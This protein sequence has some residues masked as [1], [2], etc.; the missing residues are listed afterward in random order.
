[1]QSIIRLG[2]CALMFSAVGS[3]N[4][5]LFIWNASQSI[6]NGQNPS[7]GQ[8]TGITST[9]DNVS[10]V[11]TWEV[12]FAPGLLSEGFTL[13]V[14]NGP[15]PKGHDG[16]LALFY[17]D[18]TTPATPRLTAYAY[19]AKNDA[20]S[21]KDGSQAAGNQ[22][23]D[24]ILTSLD[25]ISGSL[26][27]LSVSDENDGA[28]TMSFSIDASFLNAHNPLYPGDTPWEGA[29]FDDLIGMWFHPFAGLSTAYSDE[30]YLTN[31][32]WKSQ[33]WIDGS[34]QPTVPEPASLALLIAGL[35][36]SLA[37]RRLA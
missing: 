17:F 15:N 37:R 19:N 25:D 22:T 7:G 33:G 21:Y 32:S 2:A 35:A 26:L 6:I 5:E 11:F 14:N 8:V 4:A 34:N 12:H 24:R 30:G 29:A 10:E 3:A 27:G 31:W 13:A 16:E 1:M 28:R 9:F 20:T 23:P 18:A 36:G